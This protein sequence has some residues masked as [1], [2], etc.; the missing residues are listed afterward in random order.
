MPKIAFV[1]RICVFVAHYLDEE[2]IG[3]KAVASNLYGEFECVRY[4][5]DEGGC[6][7]ELDYDF[8]CTKPEGCK[9]GDGRK[10]PKSEI[11]ASIDDLDIGNGELYSE[12]G[13]KEKP[14]LH[15]AFDGDGVAEAVGLH[16]RDDPACNQKYCQKYRFYEELIKERR[17]RL[18]GKKLS[19]KLKYID[20]TDLGNPQIR[21]NFEFA[22]EDRRAIIAGIT[23]IDLECQWREK[24]IDSGVN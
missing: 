8:I 13:R 10:Y 2:Y 22:W 20:R 7:H 24:C 21:N 23:P 11:T 17:L 3:D 9:T 15:I 19:D 5:Y 4:Y 6:C 14:A 18:C 1:L 12:D 16:D